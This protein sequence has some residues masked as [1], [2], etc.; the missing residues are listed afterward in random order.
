MTTSEPAPAA[1][2]VEP[3]SRDEVRAKRE[4]RAA[5]DEAIVRTALREL[6]S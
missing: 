3:L 6:R 1:V 4:V 5:R 2:C